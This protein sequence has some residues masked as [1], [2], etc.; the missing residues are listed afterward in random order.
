MRRSFHVNDGLMI[1]E[2]TVPNTCIV[3]LGSNAVQISE[4]QFEELCSLRYTLKFI[5]PLETPNPDGSF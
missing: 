1:S 3:Q 2:S 5:Q 4:E